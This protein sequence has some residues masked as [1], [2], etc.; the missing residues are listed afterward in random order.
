MSICC[1]AH[2]SSSFLFDEFIRVLLLSRR[3]HNCAITS[4]LL[5]VPP[6]KLF[7]T[8]SF[9]FLWSLV[10]CQQVP[11]LSG[12]LHILSLN[13]NNTYFSPVTTMF[14]FHFRSPKPYCIIFFF[15]TSFYLLS[16]DDTASCDYF[17]KVRQIV[18]CCLLFLLKFSVT[19]FN[20]LHTLLLSL[21][22]ERLALALASVAAVLSSVSSLL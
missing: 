18:Y 20:P 2:K 6:V 3:I 17:P 1:L 21:C 8:L 10:R 4:F 12:C 7:L 11:V 16:L 22:L 14:C 19:F 13:W 5:S 9:L 15:F